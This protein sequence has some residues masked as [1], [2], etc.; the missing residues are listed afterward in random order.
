MKKLIILSMLLTGCGTYPTAPSMYAKP[1]IPKT[2]F[3]EVNAKPG[4]G[5]LQVN[6]VFEQVKRTIQ[7]KTLGQ[8]ISSMT[9]TV[10]GDNLPEPIVFTVNQSSWAGK[11]NINI[12]FTD[13]LPGDV[14]VEV[15]EKDSKNTVLFYGSS[16]VSI[17]KD[18]TTVTTITAVYDKGGVQIPFNPNQSVPS[19]AG[20]VTI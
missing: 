16:S 20:S 7:A 18:T 11:P 2:S 9:F 1:I 10:T 15:S 17:V 3:T 8:I 6:L 13:L 19:G 5:T 12:N 14:T 4:L